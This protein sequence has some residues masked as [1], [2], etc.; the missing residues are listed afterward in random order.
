MGFFS[1][2][3]QSIYESAWDF[4][5]ERLNRILEKSE[6][7]ESKEAF[8]FILGVMQLQQMKAVQEIIDIMYNDD[9][10][11]II[12]S[13]LKALN[14]WV[15]GEMTNS[16]F[17]KAIIEPRLM[18]S[19]QNASSLEQEFAKNVASDLQKW[20]SENAPAHFYEHKYS[21]LCIKYSS[22]LNPSKHAE[23]PTSLHPG[24]TG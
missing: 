8:F 20:R 11:R 1:P 18:S 21:L 3:Q 12:N 5:V 13:F 19:D 22:I 17:I 4:I 15:N 23:R 10:V 7:A 9:K 2:S 14:G 16:R 24:I 6:S